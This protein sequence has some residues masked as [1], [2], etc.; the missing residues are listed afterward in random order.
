MLVPCSSVQEEE[1]WEYLEEDR[2]LQ[3]YNLH[4]EVSQRERE[5]E[6]QRGEL[7]CE[8]TELTLVYVSQNFS[9]T[10]VHTVLV[11]QVCK[12]T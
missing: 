5:K 12:L 1:G 6:I 9:S 2:S 8:A 10:S 11:A 4:N 3:D 7:L